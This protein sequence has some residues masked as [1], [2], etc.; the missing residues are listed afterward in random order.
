MS[1]FLHPKKHAGADNYCSYLTSNTTDEAFDFPSTLDLQLQSVS[2]DL[3]QIILQR[4][5]ISSSLLARV[6]YAFLARLLCCVKYEHHALE[7]KLLH[8]LHSTYQAKISPARRRNASSSTEQD[9]AT[10]ENVKE[11]PEAETN[12]LLSHVLVLAFSTETDSAALHHWVD[13]LFLSV[14]QIHR[15]MEE[16]VYPLMNT[17]AHRL[18]GLTDEVQEAFDARRKG[19]G[20]AS[21]VNDLDFVALAGLLERLVTYALADE[22]THVVEPSSTTSDKSTAAAEPSGGF[23]TY[24]TG[25]LGSSEAQKPN[26]PVAQVGSRVS[27][28]VSIA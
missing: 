12:I 27:L 17:V 6:R 18:H 5:D 3:L 14:V 22:S 26:A 16:L 7:N 4:S 28:C 25:V 15:P 11:A 9:S 19:K 21:T 24:M 20:V 1:P 13:F 23:L 8:A 10:G 2:I